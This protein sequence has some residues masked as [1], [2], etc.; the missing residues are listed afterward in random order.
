MEHVVARG[1]LAS[2]LLAFDGGDDAA[3]LAL[4]GPGGPPLDLDVHC[5]EI[6][7]VGEWFM[8]LALLRPGGGG[9]GGEEAEAVTLAS[10]LGF[11]PV[12]REEIMDDEGGIAAFS[13][14]LD[15][16]DGCFLR[17]PP[18]LMGGGAPALAYRLG[19]V[20]AELQVCHDDDD[21]SDEDATVYIYITTV[22]GGRRRQQA[23]PRARTAPAASVS[24][25]RGGGRRRGRWGCMR[26]AAARR[27]R[28]SAATTTTTTTPTISGSC[29]G[30]QVGPYIMWYVCILVG[31]MGLPRFGRRRLVAVP[32]Q[33]VAAFH[34][35]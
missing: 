10:Q 26:G 8:T 30:G 6:V 35:A 33:S 32:F 4:C 25:D 19:F 12:A 15:S 2:K 22:A 1:P 31:V 11:R 17:A 14:E 34:H 3:L 23:G 5:R 29:S 16:K 28:T 13:G 20:L 21:N 9:D 7:H 18:A 27:P 24:I